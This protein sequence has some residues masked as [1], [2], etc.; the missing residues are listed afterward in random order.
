M[1]ADYN[2]SYDVV[3]SIEEK[4]ENVKIELKALDT[5]GILK[6]KITNLLSI[7]FLKESDLYI[8]NFHLNSAFDCFLVTNI[9][10]IFNS[11][12]NLRVEKRPT[13]IIE[14]STNNSIKINHLSRVHIGSSESKLKNV[15]NGLAEQQQKHDELQKIYDDLTNTEKTLKSYY[16]EISINLSMFSNNSVS[17]I[18]DNEEMGEYE[19]LLNQLVKKK[20]KLEDANKEVKQKKDL[21]EKKT[22]MLLACKLKEK[23]ALTI[24]KKNEI[25]SNQISSLES[26]LDKYK[27]KKDKLVAR[28]DKLFNKLK[29]ETK[30]NETILKK[31]SEIMIYFRKHFINF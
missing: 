31:S 25:L 20:K 2:E 14:N 22:A 12:E 13:K 10:Q 28:E 27:E 6:K 11:S 30:Q 15:Y 19:S 16:R 23:K 5:V 24:I 7:D 1:C 17:I 9:F 8:S 18:K 26:T 4:G 21:F 29:K 3:I